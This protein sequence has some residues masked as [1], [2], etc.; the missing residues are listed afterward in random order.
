MAKYF[1]K[2]IKVN[3]LQTQA[4]QRTQKNNKT[5]QAFYIQTT[6][7][8]RQL[9]NLGSMAE[10]TSHLKFTKKKLKKLEL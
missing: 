8:K 3:K 9:G 4:S 1:P 2:L 7:N 10:K 5:I 6:E